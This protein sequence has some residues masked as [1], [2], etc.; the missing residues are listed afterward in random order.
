M[1]GILL[2][3]GFSRRFGL[4]DK[5]LQRLPDGRTIAET[6]AQT[7]ITALPTSVAAV[8][9]ENTQLGKALE[10]LGFHVAYCHSQD[11]EMADSLV[12]ALRL[13]AKLKTETKGYVIA[14]ADMPTISAHTI[15]AVANEVMAGAHIVQPTYQAQRGHPVGFS[16]KYQEDLLRLKGDEGAKSIIQQH[17]EHLKLLPCDDAGILADIDTLADLMLFKQTAISNP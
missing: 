12:T 15:G 9:A 16:I 10:R 1:I 6:A 14:L 7:F 2:A 4:E 13:A 17:K 3:A 5:L 11:K 8:R